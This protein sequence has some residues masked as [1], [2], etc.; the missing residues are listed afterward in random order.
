MC[1]ATHGG[2]CVEQ[3]LDSLPVSQSWSKH[4]I[5]NFPQTINHLGT[6]T[7]YTTSCF[8]AFWGPCFGNPIPLL[9]RVWPACVAPVHAMYAQ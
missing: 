8:I 2:N 6:V 4:G 1:F 3:T 7:V 9:S 5:S